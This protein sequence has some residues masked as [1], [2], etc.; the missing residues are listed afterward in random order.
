MDKILLVIQLGLAPHVP[1]E[2]FDKTAMVKRWFCFG[3]CYI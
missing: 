2:V 3:D 1:C